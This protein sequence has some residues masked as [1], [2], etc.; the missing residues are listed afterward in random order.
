MPRRSKIPFANRNH[1]GWW[2]FGVVEQWVPT[3]GA[4]TAKRHLVWMNTRLLRAQN[5]EQAYKKAVRLGNE[6][7]PS[8]AH[9]GEWRFAGLSMLLPIYD[10]IEDGSE[11]FWDDCGWI[12]LKRLKR[13]VKKKRELPVF[14]DRK[15]THRGG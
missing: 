1:T 9:G 6:G 2:V 13:I 4:K 3:K 8:E 7:M 11:I 5:R 12:G 10:E 14:D 15:K